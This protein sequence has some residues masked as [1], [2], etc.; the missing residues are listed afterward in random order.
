VTLLPSKNNSQNSQSPNPTKIQKRQKTKSKETEAHQVFPI[1][2][3]N[4][5]SAPKTNVTTTTARIK[6]TYR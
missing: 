1:E 6:N 4:S 3:N 5:N 2:Y